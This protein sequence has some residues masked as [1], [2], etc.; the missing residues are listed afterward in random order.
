M[1]I[2]EI[3]R[4]STANLALAGLDSPA[5][6]AEL[7]L[8][9]CLGLSR[10][11][12]YLKANEAVSSKLLNN[13]QTLLKRRVK[14]EP[15]AYIFGIQE[16]WSLDFIVTPDVLIPRPETEQLLEKVI[17][18]YHNE[19]V[20]DGLLVDL[21]CGSGVIAVVLA[22]ELKRRVL[23]V[24]IS[25]EAL[26]VTKKNCEKHGVSHLVSLL[27]SDLFSA[28]PSVPNLACVV[29]NPPYVSQQEMENGMQPEVLM[30]EPHLALDGG[31]NGLEI[32]DRLQKQLYSR[33]APGGHLF[34]ET[35]TAQAQAL[36]QMFTRKKTEKQS[37]SDVSVQ[38]DYAGHDR[39]FYA[40]MNTPKL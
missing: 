33:L 36:S 35:G 38:K 30:Y 2:C 22:K 28:L 19:Q 7:L 39:I 8:G 21:C 15:L 10:T 29:S 14:R 3:L 25:F 4:Q 16:F 9:H 12:L 26:C 6:D 17:T 37:F 18:F 31:K 1:F 27:Q 20:G 32:I 24:D 40:K 23:A 34:M 11:E 5:L 13:F